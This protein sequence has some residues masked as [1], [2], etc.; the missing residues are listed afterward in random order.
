MPVNL[1]SRSDAQPSFVLIHVAPTG[2]VAAIDK[3]LQSLV[4]GNGS[5]LFALSDGSYAVSRAPGKELRV[6]QSGRQRQAGD[7]PGRHRKHRR[8]RPGVGRRAGAALRGAR[9]Q[10]R[11]PRRHRGAPNPSMLW[12]LDT[13]RA[14]QAWR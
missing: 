13:V 6:S 4:T 12:N 8:G 11:H 3:Q 1:A 7:V 9:P 10:T 2:N 5:V 14:R